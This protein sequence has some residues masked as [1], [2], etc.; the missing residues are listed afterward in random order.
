MWQLFP[1]ASWLS[2]PPFLISEEKSWI[3]RLHLP[4]SPPP[5]HLH[6]SPGHPNIFLPAQFTSLFSGI[7]CSHYREDNK[8][9]L[10]KRAKD[11]SLDKVPMLPMPQILAVSQDGNQGR[12]PGTKV[13]IEKV[14]LSCTQE[15]QHR[16]RK[17]TVGSL[18]ELV[19][20]F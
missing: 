19:A 16:E 12:S 10:N 7:H 11:Y 8:T 15:N 3:S 14:L 18:R 20:E 17:E 1:T 2:A 13:E 4:T 5:H 9:Y 6:L